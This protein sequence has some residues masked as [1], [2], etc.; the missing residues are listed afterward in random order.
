MKKLLIAF[1]AVAAVVAVNLVFAADPPASDLVWSVNFTGTPNQFDARAAKW[2]LTLENARIA[3][4]DTDP[5]TPGV[6][7]LPPYDLAPAAALA[8]S[9][10]LM[11]ERHIGSSH[12][13]Y[14]VQA[15]EKGEKVVQMRALIP[16]ATDAMLDAAIVELTP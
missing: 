6:Q 2:R 13:G 15:A 8:S 3:G 1:Y 10:K 16:N 5:A 12:G 9:Y 7:P 4:I 14:I 11:W